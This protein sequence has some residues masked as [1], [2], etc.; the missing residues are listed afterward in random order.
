MPKGWANWNNTDNYKTTRYSE[1]KNYGS[2]SN[3]SARIDWAKQLTE[4]RAKSITVTKVFR[5]WNPLTEKDN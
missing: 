2:G 4:E 1:Y 5:G 3:T